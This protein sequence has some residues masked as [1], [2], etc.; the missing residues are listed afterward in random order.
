[1]RMADWLTY[2]DIDQLKQLNR[3]YGCDSNH[4]SKHDLICS[5]LRQMGKKSQL[6]RMMEELPPETKRFLQLIVLDTSMSYTMEELL[7]KGRAALNGANGEPRTLIVEA[8][9]RGWLFSG[10]SHRTQ[11]LYHM[12]SDTKEQM[13]QLLIE[14]FRDPLR[15]LRETPG[16]Y[17]DEEKQMLED[18]H[19]FLNFIG[20]EVVRVTNDGSIYKQQQRQLFK[21]FHIP[22]EPICQKG[23]RF[24]F[25][26]KYH[27]YPDR[28][29]LLYDYAFYK[30]YFIE[31]EEGYLSL[32][33]SGF[34]KIKHKDIQEAKDL[35]RF[36]IRLYRRPIPHL[37]MII[38]LIGLL[39]Y[40]GW[41]PAELV[42]E[43]VG[44]WISP[45]YYETEQSLF[46][47]IIQMMLHLGVL[48]TGIEGEQHYLTL[49]ESGLKW[50]QGIS[51]F[52]EQVIEDGF[53]KTS[54]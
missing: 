36:W 13:I 1:M 54:S 47:R 4:H 2:T 52:R 34:G 41:I 18:L 33:E 11:Y 31:E 5:L 32:T 26:R 43:A 50:M 40:P 20:R 49:T 42:Y 22:E 21:S 17:R 15:I 53:I 29:S 7:A 23:P 46:Q 25:G 38:R 9:K 27:L 6:K 30:G 19:H 37:P 8:M 24:G 45:Y 48:R 12:P 51:A 3:Y 14:P 10:Y 44:E 28:F 39:S 35:Y 16:F